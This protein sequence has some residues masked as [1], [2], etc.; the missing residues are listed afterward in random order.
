MLLS[1]VGPRMGRLPTQKRDGTYSHVQ[2]ADTQQ[3]TGPY[4]ASAPSRTSLDMGPIGQCRNCSAS[5][6]DYVHPPRGQVH[7]HMHLGLNPRVSANGALLVGGMFGWGSYN[8]NSTSREQQRPP[9]FNPESLVSHPQPVPDATSDAPRNMLTHTPYPSPHI[10]NNLIMHSH[11]P[12]PP[13]PSPMQPQQRMEV[14]AAQPLPRRRSSENIQGGPNARHANINPT[15]LRG[16]QSQSP[17][18]RPQSPHRRSQSPEDYHNPAPQPQSVEL[19]LLARDLQHGATA[20]N[21]A[22]RNTPVRTA[23]DTPL[24]GQSMPMPDT[25]VSPP[26]N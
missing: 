11:T 9:A 18:G 1:V 24:P 2:A 5:R 15:L 6:E 21:T 8:H 13:H 14:R 17:H 20:R 10:T 7:N 16:R 22:Y 19:S 12:Y 23:R 25:F 3:V 26:L 4:P